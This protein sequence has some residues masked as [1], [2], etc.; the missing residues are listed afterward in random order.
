MT[1]KERI[2]AMRLADKA[3]RDP[4]YTKQIGL[5]A[6]LKENNNKKMEE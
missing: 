1:V 3:C 2:L 4:V 5:S 6:K